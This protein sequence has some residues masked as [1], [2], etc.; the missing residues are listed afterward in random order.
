[1]GIGIP[2]GE[3]RPD[4]WERALGL[5]AALVQTKREEGVTHPS[6]KSG[7]T[8]SV[9]RNEITQFSAAMYGKEIEFPNPDVMNWWTACTIMTLDLCR[10]L[11]NERL[12]VSEQEIAEHTAAHKWAMGTRHIDSFGHD[13]IL[14]HVD[15]WLTELEGTQ[16]AS[17]DF[18]FGELGVT[19]TMFEE[20]IG[21]TIKELGKWSL[22]GMMIA[23]NTWNLPPAPEEGLDNE[24]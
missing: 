23:S 11:L 7:G 12:W 17:S 4:S 22:T 8:L 3:I 6:T 9:L 24:T 10:T 15:Y 18:S 13:A 19:P 2:D 5:M 21:E 14:V 20:S 1:M 16:I